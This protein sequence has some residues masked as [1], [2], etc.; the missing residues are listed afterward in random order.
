MF[1]GLD[2]WVQD[3]GFSIEVSFLCVQDVGYVAGNKKGK[4]H[5]ITLNALT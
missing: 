2:R 5:L 3:L 4:H 1:Q